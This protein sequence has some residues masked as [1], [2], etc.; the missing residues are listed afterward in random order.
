MLFIFRVKAALLAKRAAACDKVE[1]SGNFD[2]LMSQ[3]Y[4]EW[5][6]DKGDERKLPT[7]VPSLAQTMGSVLLHMLTLCLCTTI[8]ASNPLRT[9]YTCIMQVAARKQHPCPSNTRGVLLHPCA[10]RA[11]FWVLFITQT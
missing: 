5:I 1:I 3:Q 6:S 8:S 4:C 11:Y 10:H 2:R 7:R 9:V